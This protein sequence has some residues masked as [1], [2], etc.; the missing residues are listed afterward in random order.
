MHELSFRAAP[1]VIKIRVHNLSSTGTE[2]QFYTHTAMYMYSCTCQWM[3]SLIWTFFTVFVGVNSVCLC[4]WPVFLHLLM[5][6]KKQIKLREGRRGKW[7]KTR[8]RS[9]IAS[10]G[11][12]CVILIQLQYVTCI[13]NINI[14]VCN[15]FLEQKLSIISQQEHSRF[16]SDDNSST[17]RGFGITVELETVGIA[18]LE[19]PSSFEETTPGAII[20]V[21][22]H[23]YYE[24]HNEY[25]NLL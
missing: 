25:W 14:I 5:K 23:Y 18:L 4:V 15:S 16:N 20:E 22:V 6:F 12:F 1:S 21:C 19:N 7:W 9:T 24:Y 3:D 13:I 2:G 11:L 8:R 10:L 17:T